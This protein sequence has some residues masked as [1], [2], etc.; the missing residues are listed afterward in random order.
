MRF[1]LQES[2]NLEFSRG[3]RLSALERF[4]DLG[5]L[6]ENPV[7][8]LDELVV[9]IT[10]TVPTCQEIDRGFV[11]DVNPPSVGMIM[12]STYG[13][14]IFGINVNCTGPR[15]KGEKNVNF[16]KFMKDLSLVGLEKE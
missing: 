14:D 15:F 3:G 13:A 7:K 1:K 10:N 9:S 4:E 2:W 8:K 12:F 5:K 6:I 16:N 11:I